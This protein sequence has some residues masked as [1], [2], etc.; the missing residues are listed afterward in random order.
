VKQ[1]FLHVSLYPFL[2]LI[3]L[4]VFCTAD[5]GNDDLGT[6]TI[7]SEILKS[8]TSGFD[9]TYVSCTAANNSSLSPPPSVNITCHGSSTTTTTDVAAGASC[10]TQSVWLTQL[11]DNIAHDDQQL[12][13]QL[14]LDLTADDTQL[15]VSIIESLPADSERLQELMLV[16]G[17]DGNSQNTESAATA[18]PVDISELLASFISEYMDEGSVTSTEQHPNLEMISSPVHHVNL[19]TSSGCMSNGLTARSDCLNYRQALPSSCT[20]NQYDCRR[21][22]PVDN[23]LSYSSTHVLEHPTMLNIFEHPAISKQFGQTTMSNAFEQSATSHTYNSSPMSNAFGR[24]TMSNMFTQLP[25]TASQYS[26]SVT[27]YL[28]TCAYQRQA[29]NSCLMSLANNEISLGR[30]SVYPTMMSSQKMTSSPPSTYDVKPPPPS[31]VQHLA[32]GH[33]RSPTSHIYSPTEESFHGSAMVK[34]EPMDEYSEVNGYDVV[35]QQFDMTAD[36]K[37]GCLETIPSYHRGVR[38]MPMKP[39]KYPARPSRTPVPD[40]PFPCPA[41]SCDRRFSRSDELSRH[42]R[43]HT[44]HKPFQCRVCSRAFSRSDHLTTHTRTHTGEKPFHCEICSRRFSRS[45]E[46]TRHMR[47]HNKVRGGAA[48]GAKT[49]KS[50]TNDGG[51]RRQRS[52][53]AAVPA[54]RLADCIPDSTTERCLVGITTSS[55]SATSHPQMHNEG[56]SCSMVHR[57]PRGGG[58]HMGAFSVNTTSSSRSGSEYDMMMEETGRSS[59]YC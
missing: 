12:N 52:S 54:A 53:Q 56:V 4:M 40:R 29:Q 8:P 38:L 20:A 58:G 5:R 45:D 23:R 17:N 11:L 34:T 9:A 1:Y 42:L 59:L 43:I 51:A 41:D 47:V 46:K 15:L 16:A 33:S 30:S 37:N 2:L 10:D 31:Y 24:S 14:N 49:A 27:H 50:S 3:N 35:G 36:R 25:T 18:V 57:G 48:T 26:P 28:P 21:N 39:R 19:V 22:T 13:R 32:S 55:V 44:G 7:K 6:T